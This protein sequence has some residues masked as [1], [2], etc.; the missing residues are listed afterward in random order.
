MVDSGDAEGVF[1]GGDKTQHG[2][3]ARGTL[4]DNRPRDRCNSGRRVYPVVLEEI[5]M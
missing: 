2:G 5:V 4:V 3:V 1:C